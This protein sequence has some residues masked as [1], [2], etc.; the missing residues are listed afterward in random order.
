LD[1]KIKEARDELKSNIQKIDIKM[2]YWI[3]KIDERVDRLS[4]KLDQMNKRLDDFFFL[5]DDKINNI[6]RQYKN[7]T[8]KFNKELNEFLYK[9][10]SEEFNKNLESVE[11]QEY[12]KYIKFQLKQIELVN[13]ILQEYYKIAS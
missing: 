3:T 7:F 8:I 12:K 13:N 2:D 4:M 11:D 6:Q 1:N 5:Y 9:K 10:L